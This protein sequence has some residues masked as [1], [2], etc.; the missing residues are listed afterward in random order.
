MTYHPKHTSRQD[1]D[2]RAG[3]KRYLLIPLLTGGALVAGA[4]FAS[5]TSSGSGTGQARSTTSVDSVISP[6]TNAADLYPGASSTVEVAISN[7]NP[8]PIVV[9]SIS[10][11]SSALVNVSCAAGT[12]TTDARATDPTGLVQSDNVTK[13]IAAGGSGT[14]TLV[15]HM[16]ASAVDACKSQTFTLALTAALTSA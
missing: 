7:P 4:A 1:P 15:S 8:Y 5:W 10:A 16:G 12:V 3:K 11:G 2:Q 14:Y 6:G 13:T 9:N